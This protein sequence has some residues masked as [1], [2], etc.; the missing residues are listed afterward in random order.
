MG[1]QAL[2]RLVM[3]GTLAA[4]LFAAGPNAVEAPPHLIVAP[5]GRLHTRVLYSR[6]GVV[7]PKT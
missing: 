1:I 3:L 7:P 2:W 6:E 5:V 4:P